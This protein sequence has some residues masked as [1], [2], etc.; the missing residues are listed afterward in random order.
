[1]TISNVLLAIDAG[2][3][4]FKYGVYAPDGTCCSGVQKEPSHSDG[5]LEQI[6]NSYRNM[7]EYAAQ[8]GNVSAIGVSTPGPFDYAAGCSR[9]KQKFA[10]LCD[11]PL[12]KA[13]S[14]FAGGAPV[15]FCSDSNAFL[16]GE[17]SQEESGAQNVLGITIGTGFGF[18]ARHS[19][20]G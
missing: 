14:E 18:A 4:F 20:A 10:A 11:F 15:T 19:K 13:I 2:G 16:L 7:V 17:Y 6:L 3:T 5:S 12:G 1:M 8:F 9:M